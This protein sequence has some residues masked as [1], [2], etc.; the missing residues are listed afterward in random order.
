MQALTE[1]YNSGMTG[2]THPKVKDLAQQL[3]IGEDC[4][5]VCNIIVK[6]QGC[7]TLTAVR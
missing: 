2:T 6:M 4:V 5:K 3:D 1:A 7:T